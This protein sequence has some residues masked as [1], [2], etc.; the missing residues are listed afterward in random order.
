MKLIQKKLKAVITAVL[1]CA[2]SIIIIHNNSDVAASETGGGSFL[3]SSDMIHRVT[4]NLSNMIYTAYNDGEFRKGRS[5]GSKGEHYSADYI[6]NE[7]SQI[8]LSNV[9]KEQ[10][11]NVPNSDIMISNL[12]AGDG[13]LTTKLDI[14]NLG[15]SLNDSGNVQSVDCYISPRW[16]DSIHDKNYDKNLLTYN[17]SNDNLHIV[18]AE[19]YTCT[20][21]F[22]Q[23]VTVGITPLVWQNIGYFNN[24]Q[25]A[26]LVLNISGAM[27]EEFQQAYNFDFDTI[28]PNIPST[29]PSFLKDEPVPQG[30]FTFIEE[31]PKNNPN[32]MELPSLEGHEHYSEL[33]QWTLVVRSTYDK[34][35]MKAWYDCYPSCKGLIWYDYTSNSYDTGFMGTYLPIIYI[36]GT[37]GQQIISNID[38]C[39]IDFYVNQQWNT[40]IES[41][42][43]IGQ[44]TGKDPSKVTI[45]GCLYDAMLNQ[46]SVD[47]AIG[48]GIMLAI[49]KY[50]KDNDITPAYTIKFIA[51]GGE[52]YGL[53][54]AYHYEVTH[55]DEEILY[56]VD[57]NQYGY[58]QTYP[59]SVMN[60][61]TN[62]PLYILRFGRI[63]D[64]TNYEER[65][66][67]PV[68]TLLDF[69]GSLS[70]NF[71]FAA[72][73]LL[74]TPFNA[75]RKGLLFSMPLKDTG[76]YRHHRTGMNYTEGDSLKYVDWNDAYTT[77][78]LIFNITK[79][80]AI[81][82]D[83][84]FQTTPTH[85]PHDTGADQNTEPDA[86]DVTYT[87]NTSMP[88]DR[89]FVRALL[90]S[91]DHPILRRYMVEKSYI[92]TNT[93]GVSDSFTIQLPSD[94]PKGTYHLHV[95]L[96]NS[97]GEID[98]VLDWFDQGIY[99]NEKY[100]PAGFYLSPP[101]DP[102]NKPSRPNGPQSVQRWI[103]YPY[104]TSTTDPNGKQ[105]YYEW[106][107]RAN[108]IIPHYEIVGP[109]S[110][111]A[112]CVINHGWILPGE[113]QV[114]VRATNNLFNPNMYSDWSDPLTVTVTYWG[115]GNGGVGD[116]ECGGGGGG[117]SDYSLICSFA[118][119]QAKGQTYSY[120]GDPGN[121][122]QSEGKS[123]GFEWHWNFN[124]GTPI[125]YEQNPTHSYSTIGNHTVTLDL[126]DFDEADYCHLMMPVHVVTLKADFIVSPEAAQPNVTLNF[127]DTSAGE[128]TINNWTWNFGD[129]HISYQ[130]N[131]THTYT[132]SGDYN[133][134]LTV[135]DNYYPVNNIAST[136]KIIHIESVP[137]SIV[138]V[139]QSQNTLGPDSP[140]SIS[141][142]VADTMSNVKTV[143]INITYPDNT[144]QNYM[145]NT[146]TTITNGYEYTFENTS[147][148]GQYN[149]TIWAVDYA[150]NTN[151]TPAFS[152]FVSES[153]DTP[154]DLSVPDNAINISINPQLSAQMNDLEGD[155]MDVSFYEWTPPQHFVIDSEDDWTK[156]TFTNTTTD[157]YGNLQLHFNTNIYGDGSDWNKAFTEDDTLDSDK[158]Y[159]DLTINPCVTL[160]T[161]G[162]TVRVSGT[163]TN[164]GIITDSTSGGI[165]GYGGAIGVGNDPV[166]QEHGGS[167]YGPDNGHAGS[168]GTNRGGHGGAGGAGGGGAEALVID[169]ILHP[170]WVDA[171]CNGGNG[172]VGGIGGHGGG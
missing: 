88:Q 136:Y 154:T 83:C 6:E 138:S 73:A 11:T 125:S 84:H 38:N 115:G 59:S 85:Q 143:A 35:R 39:F 19:N 99:A 27:E 111:G 23:N 44:I 4:E 97:T 65:T 132:T 114:R 9:H 76:W 37:I 3:L 104:T 36:N 101:I 81:D 95:F 10:I 140:L 53:I 152:F 123:L 61:A 62:G 52:E 159:A 110:N 117:S 92:I 40:S 22:L 78:D 124:D 79:Y 169:H 148:H 33:Y 113:Y 34:L 56:V 133:V 89:I 57:M 134:T 145:M 80:F 172:G 58:Y 74:P 108:K 63:A 54:G 139:N 60:I 17:C 96:Y 51:F 18:K 106:N 26:R 146:D 120:V 50:L 21:E 55:R 12:R 16:N 48:I 130:R 14:Q 98:N 13:N 32:I 28:N 49:A 103:Q 158:N 121:N 109:Y 144:Y 87:I 166:G 15:C 7:M 86:V 72:A 68:N 69:V 2:T 75:L 107:W 24:F 31:C 155:T 167:P 90:I 67:I 25:D 161:A 5:F 8:G 129:G 116:G 147:Q 102:P 149:Y 171:D 66:G 47:S 100:E 170:L 137:S 112:T 127:N 20:D 91:D 105:I 41:Y 77:G 151:N 93:Q 160:D 131:T 1:L 71:P 119:T 126:F 153:P 46:G 122:L 162:Y 30:N 45:V 64:N 135:K 157:G 163:L 94:A 82:P 141:A 142:E 42:N 128:Y 150:N 43:V 70:D 165:G 156:G 118:T 29:F 164:Y 168:P